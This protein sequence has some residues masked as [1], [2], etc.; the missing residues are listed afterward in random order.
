MTLLWLVVDSDNLPYFNRNGRK[1]WV[2]NNWA[3]NR[4]NNYSFVVFRDC[5]IN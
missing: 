3:D 5:L 2:N 1:A 4:W